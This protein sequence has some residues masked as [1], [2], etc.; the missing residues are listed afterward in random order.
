[1]S[2]M[3]GDYLA[4]VGVF[5]RNSSGQDKSYQNE[6]LSLVVEQ[7]RQ[8]LFGDERQRCGAGCSMH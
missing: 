7:L 3:G 2:V 1:M 5:S 6:E 8:R 4:V